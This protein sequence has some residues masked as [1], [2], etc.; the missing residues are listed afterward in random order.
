MAASEAVLGW[1]PPLPVGPLLSWRIARAE[2][3]LLNVF[4]DESADETTSRTFAVA[5]IV[6]TEPQ[7]VAAEEQWLECTGG[8]IFH[9]AD[10]EHHG[11]L[12]L[13]KDLTTVLVDS[14]L[15]AYGVAIDLIAFDEI[16]PG[17]HSD[18]KYMKCFTE[19]VRY[20]VTEVA[21][22]RQESIQFT[23]DQRPQ[24]HYNAGRMYD[25]VANSRGGRL[26]P[27]LEST[28]A[29][30]NRKNPRIQMADLVAR[31]VMKA[32]DNRMLGRPPRKSLVALGESD[33]L[34]AHFIDRNYCL[35]WQKVID[36]FRQSEHGETGYAAWLDKNRLQN[37]LT[38]RIAYTAWL[39][40]SGQFDDSEPGASNE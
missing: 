23:F 3:V 26:D 10:C 35:R 5:G 2:V 39:Y 17:L 29:F 21:V 4:G 15:G 31:E 25:L 34:L 1:L 7:W 30:T 38:N 24:S 18:A 32:L 16:L 9:A 22:P 12:S 36:R 28:V 40:D 13:Y 33:T 20:L 19:V 8:E 11:G 6:G 14:D 27:F 37:N